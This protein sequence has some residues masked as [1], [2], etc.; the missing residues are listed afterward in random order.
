MPPSVLPTHAIIAVTLNCNSH[1]TMC[2]IWKN[3]TRN[4]LSASEFLKLPSSL[5]DINITGGEPFLRPDLP[6]IIKNIKH[7][8]P[9]AHLILNTNGFLPD[10]IKSH[11]P[12]LLKIDPNFAFRVS[13]DGWTDTHDKIRRFTHGF[14]LCLQSLTILRKAGVKDLGISFTIMENNY[15]EIPILMQ[16]CHEQN[17]DLSLTLASNSPIYFGQDKSSLRPNDSEDFYRHLQ[18]LIHHQ[19]LSTNPKKW[20]RAFFD[21]SLFRYSQTHHRP[22]PCQAAN[23]LF[24]LDS[25][26]NVFACHLK[27]WK[28]GNI[29]KNTFSEIWNSPERKLQRSK[30]INCHDCWMVC[31]VKPSINHLLP[32]KK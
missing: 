4:E 6:D 2:D 16:Y 1:C 14:D 27:N 31:S 29:K 24:Y 7:A 21:Y 23:S 9:K 20:F 10:L 3:K 30:S 11:I 32:W 5:L 12:I 25:T 13:L 19:L 17:L 22:V 8:S 28:I 26:G 18:P 15:R